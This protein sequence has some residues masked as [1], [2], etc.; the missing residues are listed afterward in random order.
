MV[1]SST[2]LYFFFGTHY[3]VF[4]K[5]GWRAI[6]RIRG[7]GNKNDF[8]LFS[9]CNTVRIQSFKVPKNTFLTIHFGNPSNFAFFSTKVDGSLLSLTVNIKHDRWNPISKQHYSSKARSQSCRP[10]IVLYR[11]KTVYCIWVSQMDYRLYLHVHV[12]AL[13]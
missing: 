9:V 11:D 7:R 2:D 6:F 8:Y 12:S 4:G 1:T 5:T 10:T 13:Y 3:R